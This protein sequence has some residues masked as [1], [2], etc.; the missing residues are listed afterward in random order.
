M[1]VRIIYYPH[2]AIVLFCPLLFG[3]ENLW[4]CLLYFTSINVIE[5][6]SLLKYL[7]FSFFF[8]IKGLSVVL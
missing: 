6:L 4:L 1:V 2:S 3:R 8:R 5:V 7:F